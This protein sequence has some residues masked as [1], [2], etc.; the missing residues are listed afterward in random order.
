MNNKLI[1]DIINK[2]ITKFNLVSPKNLNIKDVKKFCLNKRFDSLSIIN[3][4]M[5]FEEEIQNKKIVNDLRKQNI[6]KIFK[7]YKTIKKFFKK[8]E[9]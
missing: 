5:A 7:N 8:Y 2:S 6:N 3:L 1:E 4:T 9:A